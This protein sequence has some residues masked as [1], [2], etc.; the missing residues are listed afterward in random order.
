MNY[1]KQILAVLSLC[2]VLGCKFQEKEIQQPNVILIIT[3][4]QGY[5][6][7]GAY[8]GVAD[9]KTPNLDNLA[10]SGVRFTNAYVTM[11]ICSPSRCAILTG[12]QQQRWGVYNYSASL[13]QKEITLAEQLKNAGY[14]NGIVGKSHYGGYGG[15]KSGE[16]PLN[17]G[18]DEFYG[19]EG[20]TMDFIRHT[21]QDREK[22]TAKMANHLGIGP[23][24]DNDSLIDQQGYSTDLITSKAL[25]FIDKNKENP[26]FLTVSYNEVHLFTH[27]L[28]DTA[29]ARLGLE[30]VP[31]WNPEKGTWDEYLEWYVD[32]VKPNTPDGRKRYLWHLDQLDNS[33]GEIIDK[34]Q[35]DK[36]IENTIIVYISDNGGSPRTYADNF[37][38]RGNKYILE[39]G[40]IRVPMLMSWPGK[41]EAGKVYEPMV[42]ALD[43][44]PTVHKLLGMD[45]PDDRE[46]DG[47]NLMPFLNEENEG[48]PHRNLCWTGFAMKGKPKKFKDPNSL[49]ARYQRT[50]HGDQNGWAIR[51]GKW[52]LRFEGSYNN[53]CL[54]DLE[55]DIGEINNL[56]DKHPEIVNQLTEKFNAWHKNI[57][58]DVLYKSE[59][60]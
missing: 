2:L 18:Y 49:A 16:F 12:R 4:D 32:A 60:N 29:L 56:A 26:F 34:L 39:E 55:T 52:K 45:M 11:S 36:L 1:K 8:G 30:K 43:I 50:F 42:S 3:D 40:G 51:E 48:I 35:T 37:P 5:G 44:F 31:D 23:F 20:G 54:Y 58:G 19:K 24:Y 38:L 9:V 22:F 13:P 7:F 14:R 57:S 6:D 27:Q 53:F 59:N 33:V 46:Y 25:S 47:V 10:E 28:P 21:A 41:I 17:H 15:H